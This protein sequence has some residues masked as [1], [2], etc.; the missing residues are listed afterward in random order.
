MNVG[1]IG[2][3]SMG[4]HVA[5]NI[6]EDGFMLTVYDVRT[7]CIQE[8]IKMGAGEAKNAKE[9][10]L[11][12][13]IVIL[14]VNSY[15]QCLACLTGKNGLFEGMK[16]GII[17]V[18]STI[19]FDEV[20][21]IEKMCLEAGLRM[22][23]APVSGGTKG[24][25]DR[26][27]TVMA[28]GDLAVYTTCLPVLRS[29]GNNIIHIGSEIGQGQKMKA[30]NQLLVG[31]HMVATAE[32]FCLA[33][34]CGLNLQLVFKTIKTCAGTSRIFENRAKSI[35]DKDFSTKSSLQ[36]QVKD[37]DISLKTAK[38]FDAPIFLGNICRELFKTAGDKYIATDDS[39]SVIK[40]YEE[41]NIRKKLKINW[42]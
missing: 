40:I 27:L 1:I 21:I 5:K 6:F 41:P 15:D 12:S 18:S 20:K 14:L 19:S 34:R 17:I 42:S 36:I 33:E 24:A 10:G 37:M 35:I 4:R 7:E 16:D 26:T 28:A 23:D 39:I 25:M 22:L 29:I 11:N 31:I 9:V 30:I 2:L 38:Y 8:F 32:A 3:G 13:E